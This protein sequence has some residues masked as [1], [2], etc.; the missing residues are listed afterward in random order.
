[1]VKDDCNSLELRVHLNS[2]HS[3]WTALKCALHHHLLPLSLPLY[4]PSYSPPLP[5]T[6]L[7]LPPPPPPPPSQH[8]S[9]YE[10]LLTSQSSSTGVKRL[11]ASFVVK[12]SPLFPSL[13]VQALDCLCDLLE[14]EDSAV[15]GG[16]GP[17]V[18]GGGTCISNVRQ[19]RYVRK[20][21]E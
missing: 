16:D 19:A 7:L 9:E 5:P 21:R 13:V 14:D 11:A 3:L 15:R 20:R 6:L 18:W 17:S 2:V 8:Q 10:L 12:F 4:V 1:M